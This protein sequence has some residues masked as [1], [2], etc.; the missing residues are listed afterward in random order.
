MYS[1]LKIDVGS[2]IDLSLILI[3]ILD[4]AHSHPM[5]DTWCMQYKDLHAKGA[6]A[7]RCYE[8]PSTPQAMINRFVI[9]LSRPCGRVIGNN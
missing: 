3:L 7:S 4:S 5:L 9:R 6:G 8:Q 2:K 1:L